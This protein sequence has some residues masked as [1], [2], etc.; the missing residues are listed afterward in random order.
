MAELGQADLLLVGGAVGAFVSIRAIAGNA[1]A[2][3]ILGWGIAL[4]LLANLVVIGKQ[5]QDPDLHAGFPS[6]RGGQMISGFFAHY[7]EAANYL[8][9]SSMLV[10]A[11][12]LVRTP[13]HRH[14]RA[15]AP[16]S[17][18]R[19]W[20]ASG[21]PARAAASSA[22][23]WR[24]GV[25]AAVALMIGKRRDARWFAP[26]LIAIPVIGLAIGA[27]LFMGWQDAQETRHA[28]QRTSIGLLD[29]DCRLY[30]LGI[31]LSCIGLHPL[32]GGGS[33]SF[34]WECFRFVD[35]KTNRATHRPTSRNWFTTN[36]SKPPPITAW[37]EPGCWSACSGRWRWLAILRLLFEDRPR[38][39]DGSDAWRLGAL[40]G[41][42]GM[43]VQSCFSFVFHLM[44]GILLLGICLGQMSRS[45]ERAPRPQTLG[46]RILLTARRASPAPSCCCPPAGRAAR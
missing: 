20:Q 43:L 41:L 29:N 17:P 24:C 42:A 28:G 27:F 37:W 21:S 30:L 2:E 10:G 4:L 26:A 16:D 23:P 5:L 39:H 1:A 32:A 31:A 25:F 36:W 12:A 15:V 34:S 19:D 40:A 18:S 13:R 45:A 46:T 22:R 8:I 38:E 44:P 14:P 6:A 9:A 33:R 11:A 35:D 3:R 7:N